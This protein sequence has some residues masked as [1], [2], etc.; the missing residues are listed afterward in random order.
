[1]SYELVGVDWNLSSWG[2][3]GNLYATM[4]ARMTSVSAS[5][6]VDADNY[7]VTQPLAD[8]A[9]FC[10]GLRSAR[11]VITG[12]MHAAP[13]VGNFGT[14][15]YTVGTGYTKLVKGYRFRMEAD[16]HDITAAPETVGG[17]PPTWRNFR[18]DVFQWGGQFVCG[19][20]SGTAATLPPVANTYNGSATPFP[21]IQLAY[22][23]SVTPETFTGQ[24]HIGPMEVAVGRGQDA[25]YI[26]GFQG[27]GALTSAG[28]TPFIAAG[29][30]TAPL[31]SQGGSAVGAMVLA[32]KDSTR[33]FTIADTFWQ[34]IEITSGVGDVVGVQ[35]VA[36]SCGAITPT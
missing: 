34:S 28:T 35:I 19:V 36:Q 11:V 33:Y 13:K 21:T 4:L 5:L 31:W 8:V 17:T 29:T 25:R 3:G 27:S 15:V 24:A 1:M 2:T 10:A 23:N 14:V 7:N 18:P 30:V 26:Y 22:G 9:A 20:D 6:L 16:I 12:Q 32:P